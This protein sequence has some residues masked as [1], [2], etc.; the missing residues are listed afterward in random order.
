MAPRR[1][2]A[3][4]DVAHGLA[5]A[6]GAYVRTVAEAVGVPRE[7]TT[8]EVTDTATAYLA[9]GCRST[10]HPDR[11]VMLVWSASQ[12]WVVSIETSPGEPP[13][14]LSRSTGDLVPAPEAVARFV[15]ESVTRRGSGLRPVI[16]PP[17]ADWSDLAERME[18]RASAS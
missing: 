6:L 17:Y 2:A 11:D 7:G 10:E 14:V 18:L 5:R 4:A 12:G 15:A 16:L 8:C 9:L 13:I 3:P 1:R